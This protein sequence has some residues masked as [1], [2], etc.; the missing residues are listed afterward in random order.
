MA[1]LRLI[2]GRRGGVE[3][4]RRRRFSKRRRQ[5]RVA[6]PINQLDLFLGDVIG[7]GECASIF[8]AHE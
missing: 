1:T 7:A 4:P 6:V 2:P 3:V 8:D 5:H